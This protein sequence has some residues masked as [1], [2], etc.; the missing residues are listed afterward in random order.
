MRV[1]IIN[2]RIPS[3][4]QH[5]KHVGE[6]TV[7]KNW[8][9]VLL[10]SR[11]ICLKRYY[12]PVRL[13]HVWFHRQSPD[14]I[15]RLCDWDWFA[16]NHAVSDWD[17]W[18]RFNCFVECKFFLQIWSHMWH[19]PRQFCQNNL[20][21]ISC[22]VSENCVVIILPNESQ[23]MLEAVDNFIA[24]ITESKDVFQR[25]SEWKCAFWVWL[26]NNINLS[27]CKTYFI[28]KMSCCASV[29]EPQLVQACA[30]LKIIWKFQQPK[31]R[32]CLPRVKQTFNLLSW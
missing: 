16:L 24:I 7:I 29:S 13:V 12:H 11:F 30:F 14:E 3:R 1:I 28:L 6:I 5:N 21:I 2:L 15:S 19:I 17:T 20:P 23:L 26:L 22:V 27:S 8:W 25:N 10:V 32:C 31:H 4:I 18:F 9:V